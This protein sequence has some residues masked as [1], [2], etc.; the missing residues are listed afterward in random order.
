MR[1]AVRGAPQFRH[2]RAELR[3]ASLTL[4]LPYNDVENQ[5]G[6]TAAANFHKTTGFG[7]GLPG[8]IDNDYIVENFVTMTNATTL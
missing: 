7:F 1:Q 5:R 6:K 4:H 2:G 3:W 8:G